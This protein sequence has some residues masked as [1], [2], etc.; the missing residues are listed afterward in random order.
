[1]GER[2]VAC[3][4]GSSTVEWYRS[5]WGARDGVLD[6]V[7]S[8]DHP[9]A[10]VAAIDWRPIPTFPENRGL[11]MQTTEIVYQIRP[12]GVDV[13]VP[14]WFG[15]GLFDPPAEL[16][17]GVLVPVSSL[18]EVRHLRRSHRGLKAEIL[19]AVSEGM[20]P[21]SAHTLSQQVSALVRTVAVQFRRMASIYE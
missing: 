20:H 7:L 5:R 3:V 4:V 14:L 11:D 18:S 21:A 12:R 19:D 16:T 6:A 9:I 13:F 2:A 1:M 15:T 8:T 10:E 17:E